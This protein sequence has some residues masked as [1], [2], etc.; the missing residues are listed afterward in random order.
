MMHFLS[1]FQLSALL[2]LAALAAKL[3]TASAQTRERRTSIGINASTLQ[4]QGDFGSDYWKFNSS[5]YAPGVAVNLYLFRGLDLN[6]QFFYGQLTGQRSAASYFNT[7]LLNSTLGLK[8]KLNNGWALKEEA[9][10]QPYLLAGGGWTYASRVGL[11]DGNRIDEDKGYIDVMGGAGI[12]LRLGRGVSFFVQSSQHLPLHANLD[13]VPALNNPRWADRFLQH[14]VGLTFNMGQARDIDEDG[15]PDRLDQCPKTPADIEVDAHGCPLD[16]DH[17][18]VPNYQDQ[19]PNDPGTAEM[20]GC[21]DT[22]KDGIDDVDDV[23]PDTPGKPELHGC[24]D[25]DNDGVTDANDN[26]LDTPAGAAVDANGCSV[27][28]ATTQAN[29]DSAQTTATATDTDG[30]GTPNATDRCPNDAGPATNHGCPEI[31]ARDRQRLRQATLFIG[32]ERNQATLLP[33]SYAT[34]DTIAQI[35]TQYPNYSLSIAGHTDSQGSAAYNLRLSQ[36]RAA[37]ARRYLLSKG[38]ADTRVELR[39]YGSS[40]PLADNATEA[41]RIRNRRVEFDLFLTGELNAAQQ[42]YGS[43]PTLLSVAPPAKP[44]L[45]PAKKRSAVKT[46]RKKTSTKSRK[47]AQA[48]REAAVPSTK[49][50]SNW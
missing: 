12:S 16:D 14:T 27:A 21:P 7:T 45:A 19:C 24:P 32:F 4:Y 35:L 3:P 17:D 41:G 20:R 13:G 10:V 2:L 5:Q 25:T 28:T 43:A 47:P 38:S 26:C 1:R 34:L 44:K 33:S 23:C 30:D 9:R 15:V 8:F 48:V 37:A 40:H 18:G 39:G 36:E 29:P 42:K 31:K 50:D 22:D 11:T 6:T 49:R 46:S